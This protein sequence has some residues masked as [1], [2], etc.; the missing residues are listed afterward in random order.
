MLTIWTLRT[1]PYMPDLIGSIHAGSDC[2]LLPI[3]YSADRL[4]LIK[5][6]LNRSM[7]SWSGYARCWEFPF[8]GKIC[9]ERQYRVCFDLHFLTSTP[10]P[11]KRILTHHGRIVLGKNCFT[12]PSFP[13][14]EPEA[15]PP[16][17]NPKSLHRWTATANSPGN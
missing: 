8:P 17:I 2:W 15:A 11:R 1:G 12:I 3:F 16:V 13:E 7:A 10:S 6:F 4:V 9:G 5:D 14:R